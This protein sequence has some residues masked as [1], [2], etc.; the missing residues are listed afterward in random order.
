ME[1][2]DDVYDPHP[3]PNCG[4]LCDCGDADIC[5]HCDDEDDF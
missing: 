5:D 1:D 3:C 4:A 2:F